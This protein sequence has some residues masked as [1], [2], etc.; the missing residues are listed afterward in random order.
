MIKSKL[1][2]R[3]AF[4]T[5][6]LFACGAHAEADWSQRR[7]PANDGISSET[8]WVHE[9]PKEGPRVLWKSN[10]GTGYSAVSVANG[11]AFTIGNTNDADAVFCVDAQTGL[12]VWKFAYPEPLNPKMYEGGPNS[13][14][15]VKGKRVFVASRTGKIFC[16]ESTNG[17][18]IWSNNLAAYVGAKNG[19][20]GLG[21]SPLVSGTRV[22][23]NYGS[24]VVALDA[25]SGK[26]LWQSAK[27]EKG[28]YSFTTPILI[29]AAGQE[30]LLAHMQ[31]SLF[32]L[33]LKDGRELWRHPFGSGYET[34]SADPVVT[35]AGVFISSGD[36]GGELVSFTASKE[37]RLWKNKNLSTFTGTAVL[38]GAH[39][40][41]V[42]AGGYKKGKQ[43]FRCIDLEKGEVKWSLPGFGQDS[44]LGAGDRLIVL[45]ERGE[46]LVVKAV[47]ERGQ[48]LSRAQV[49]GGS[50]WTQPTLSHGLLYCRNS[51]GQVVCLD[52]RRSGV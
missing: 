8:N 45:T 4:V 1:F 22:Y 17:G 28:K 29:P 23:L 36:D 35:P 42:D 31:K 34:H 32:A 41:G 9:W 27:E 39:L 21:G 30:V 51:R 3:I 49:L 50:C 5:S 44:L 40:Y 24:A 12:P 14:P 6:A 15:T 19:D 52:L 47:P 33:S 38:V 46:L 16:L 2:T 25:D 43:E 10:V 18:L 48:I 7:G 26:A 37:A 13:T 11:R 20:W